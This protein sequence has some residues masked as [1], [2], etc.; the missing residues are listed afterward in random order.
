MGEVL[1]TVDGSCYIVGE[2]EIDGI[3][4]NCRT[5][6]DECLYNAQLFA[7]LPEKIEE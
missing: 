5:Q 4:V 3:C 1:A 6:V 7:V 2:L